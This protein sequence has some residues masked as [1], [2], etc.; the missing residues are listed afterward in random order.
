MIY[1]HNH[2]RLLYCFAEI[3][4]YPRIHPLEIL[5]EC[6]LLTAQVD[7][8]AAELMHQFTMFVEA[9][10]LGRL[11]EIYTATFDLDAAYHAYIGHQL[12]GESYKRS[13]FILGLKKRYQ[14]QGFS[15]YG[16]ELP[17]HL[18]VMLRFLSVCDDDTMAGE[19]LRDALIPVLKRMAKKED[20]DETAVANQKASGH[21]DNAYPLVLQSLCLVLEKLPLALRFKAARIGQAAKKAQERLS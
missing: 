12:F 6:H 17:D 3:L 18:P 15:I 10:P 13:A 16:T 21:S 9:R 11:Q 4:D 14:A 8:E 1:A 19:I 7:A 2:R 5:H 20:A